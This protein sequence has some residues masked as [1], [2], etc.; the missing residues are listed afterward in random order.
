MPKFT[1]LLLL[2]IVSTLGL[3]LLRQPYSLSAAG[4]A[5]QAP[6]LDRSQQPKQHFPIA[7]YDELE[8][9]DAAKNAEKMLPLDESS[10]FE[11]LRGTS[12][13]ELLTQ[14]RTIVSE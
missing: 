11:A 7:E 1:Y 12:S 2:L 10:Q 5:Q 3:L 9:P 4:A 8:L 14:V 6:N 13:L